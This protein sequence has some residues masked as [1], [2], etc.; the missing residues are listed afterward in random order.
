MLR[1][2]MERLKLPLPLTNVITNLFLNRKNS[3]FTAYGNTDPYDVIVGIDQGEVISPL[4]WVIYYDPLL[5]RIGKSSLGYKMSVTW[6]PDI[7]KTDTSEISAY[8]PNSTYMD[9]TIWVTDNL[10]NLTAIFDIA[11]F[12]FD[13]NSMKVNHN[14]SFILTTEAPD[15]NITIY[16]DFLNQPISF[17]TKKPSES[18]RYLGV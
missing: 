14:K 15:V 10:S 18:T 1:K 4:L 8:I 17:L 9:D 16:S 2:A 5:S 6:K 13:L 7:T 3:V 12:F 11:Q